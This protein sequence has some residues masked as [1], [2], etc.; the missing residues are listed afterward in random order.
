M[1]EATS[2]SPDRSEVLRRFG[3]AVRSMRQ[4]QDLTQEELA[5]RC[6]V[7]VTYISQIERGQKNLSLY[8][9]HRLAVALK[10]SPADLF[11]AGGW[12]RP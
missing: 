6:E 4:G 1:Q 9:V 5:D 12:K 8:K 7:H 10:V 11:D 3:G 2:T